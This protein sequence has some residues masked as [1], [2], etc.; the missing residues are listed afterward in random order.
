[1]KPTKRAAERLIKWSSIL[2]AAEDFKSCP[3]TVELGDESV[4]LFE[5]RRILSAAGENERD[6]AKHGGGDE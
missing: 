5:T 2:L 1:M 6:R 3:L 4:G